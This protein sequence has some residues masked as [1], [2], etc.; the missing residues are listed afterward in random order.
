MNY[1]HSIAN[2]QSSD[3][4]TKRND[5][6]GSIPALNDGILG[7][8][9]LEVGQEPDLPIGWVESCTFDADEDFP[10]V[11]R[12][13]V[14]LGELVG[15][16]VAHEE[17]GFLLDRE[18][19]IGPARKRMR[20]EILRVSLENTPSLYYRCEYPK[21]NSRELPDTRLLR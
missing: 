10:C 19:H 3:T 21:V 9:P 13:H 15:T 7:N 18:G 6:A 4:L 16:A 17:K 8:D 12:G 11:E 5:H 20:L 14:Y 2:L 1:R